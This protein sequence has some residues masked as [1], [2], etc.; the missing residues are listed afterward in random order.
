MIIIGRSYISPELEERWKV[1]ENHIAEFV[2]WKMLHSRRRKPWSL[3]D[4]MDA[5]EEH[6]ESLGVSR[7]KRRHINFGF[8]SKRTF[9]TAI[10]VLRDKSYIKEDSGYHYTY[11]LTEAGRATARKIESIPKVPESILKY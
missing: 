7:A 2:I 9:Q 1:E 8:N 6:L 11:F 10:F 4:M 3:D 5:Y